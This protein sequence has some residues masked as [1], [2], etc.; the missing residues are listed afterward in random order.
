MRK[1]AR[2]SF[3]PKQYPH[4]PKLYHVSVAQKARLIYPL[5]VHKCA[6]LRAAVQQ[7][8]AAVL[9]TNGSMLWC[10][11]AVAEQ[12][13]IGA[14]IAAHDSKRL[15]NDKV[16]ALIVA[17]KHAHPG[18]FEKLLYEADKEPGEQSD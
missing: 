17:G 1:F 10:E 6:D 3:L 11:A 15:G 8:M 4:G 14:L 12:R 13:N 2:G 16:S 7:N 9:H 5:T 18:L